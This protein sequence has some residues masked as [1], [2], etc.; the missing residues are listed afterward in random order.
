LSVEFGDEKIGEVSVVQVLEWRGRWRLRGA[1]GFG[2]DDT[3]T[4][5]LSEELR[6]EILD[7]WFAGGFPFL[8]IVGIMVFQVFRIKCRF[9]EISK[10]TD[11]LRD[12]LS[13]WADLQV[14]STTATDGKQR[15]PATLRLRNVSSVEAP[16]FSIQ[17]PCTTPSA[18]GIHHNASQLRNDFCH[19]IKQI[20]WPLHW[21]VTKQYRDAT[22]QRLLQTLEIYKLTYIT[23]SIAGD[24]HILQSDCVFL[25]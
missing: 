19:L 2:G 22:F 11:D 8:E 24:N 1:V 23:A 13:S 5:A 3:P 25:S 21:N 7:A 20:R 14:W 18:F 9:K 6:R 10:S 16:F 4:F 15:Q 12:D 17:K